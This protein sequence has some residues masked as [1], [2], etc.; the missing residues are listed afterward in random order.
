M[1]PAPNRSRSFS[2][3]ETKVKETGLDDIEESPTPTHSE[4][5]STPTKSTSSGPEPLFVKR[6]AKISTKSASPSGKEVGKMI[7]SLSLEKYFVKLIY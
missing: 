2:K 3:E 7:I 4:E 6:N 5:A 1:L